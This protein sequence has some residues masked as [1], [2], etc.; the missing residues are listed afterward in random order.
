MGGGEIIPTSDK[1]NVRSTRTVFFVLFCF[2]TAVSPA[3]RI[4]PKTKWV[5]HKFFLNEPKKFF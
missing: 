2:F 5:L 4:G 3:V 1:C